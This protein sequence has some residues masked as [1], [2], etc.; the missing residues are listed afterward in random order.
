[1]AYTTA[2]LVDQIKKKAFIPSTQATFTDEEL[3]ELA[4]D[5]MRDYIVPLIKST[6]EEYYLTFEDFAIT[7]EQ[8]FAR[9]PPR[10]LG[11]ALREVAF[12]QGGVERNM[13]RLSIEDKVYNEANGYSNGFYLQGD[14]VYVFGSQSGTMRLY[15][16]IRTGKLVETTDAA[17]I[18]SIDRDTGAI[19]CSSIPSS[20]GVSNTIDFIRARPGFEHL[21]LDVTINNLDTGTNT[22]TFATGDIP[23]ELE[24]GDWIS[25]EDTSPV[26]QIP[27]EWFS[28]LAQAVAAQ[29]LE[30]LGDIEAAGKAEAKMMRIQ[31]NILDLITARVSGEAKKF[32]PKRNRGYFGRFYR[33][34]Y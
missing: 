31:K 32:V 27:P 2:D 5:E 11:M 14:K 26:P 9:I 21:A 4:T 1:M 13:P 17:N 3:L 25:L 22:I 8:K 29:V 28:Y 16:L 20:W 15:Y 34:N 23:E 18:T 7:N 24:V 30:S 6:R 19:V 10:A 33:G 12:I